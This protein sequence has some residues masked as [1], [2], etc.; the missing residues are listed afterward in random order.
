MKG[1]KTSDVVRAVYGIRARFG[2][3]LYKLFLLLTI[4]VSLAAPTARTFAIGDDTLDL[5][6]SNR[7][8]YYN[9]DGGTVN[10]DSGQR[11]GGNQI[12]LIGDSLSVGAAKQISNKMPG[13]NYEARTYDGVKY[14]LIQNSKHFALDVPDNA[15]GITIAKKLKEHNELREYLIFAL[16]TNDPGA[17]KESTIQ[18]LVDAVGAEQKIVLV[19]NASDGAAGANNYDSNNKAIRDAANANIKVADWA[20]VVGNNSYGYISDSNY[21]VHLSENGD[22]A[23]AQT[24]YDGVYQFSGSLSNMSGS[25][26]GGKV[27]VGNTMVSGGSNEEVVWNWL[28]T[29]IPSLTAEQ[30]SAIMGNIKGGSS[31]NP[32]ADN[33]TYFGIF[34]MGQGRRSGLESF[35][36]ANGIT[37]FSG[38]H[39]K[40]EIYK[41]LCLELEYAFTKDERAVGFLEN[42][43]RVQ[44]LSGAEAVKAY[45][46]IW[47]V[48]MEGAINTKDHPGQPLAYKEFV[49]WSPYYNDGHN[50]TGYYQGATTREE[51][52]VQFY[53]KF[54]NGTGSGASNLLCPS[55]GAIY[56]VDGYTFPI[57]N[58]TKSNYLNPGGKLETAL[59]KL[60]C[61]SRACHHDYAAVDMGIDA[62]SAGFTQDQSEL[63][64]GYSDMY[65]YSMGAKVVALTSGKFKNY[66]TYSN[67]V[68]GYQDKCA[69]VT[70]EADDGKVF[71]LGHMSYD[72]AMAQKYR[73]GDHIEEGEVIG[74]I[75]PPQCA[76]GTQA[77]L[78]VQLGVHSDS[79]A[80]DEIFPLMDKLWEALPNG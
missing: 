16:G 33:G 38:R 48:H 58:A 68:G 3:V 23:Y 47:V 70:F 37:S 62:V 43:H 69:S 21:H 10:C 60:P 2:G 31:F 61:P 63:G 28:T 42:L 20:E 12:T 51:Y 59:S 44:G 67:A 73:N 35:L 25:G 27:P 29:N 34:Q 32:F 8:Y 36:R 18:E 17:V 65:Y 7:A 56:D 15:S 49:T 71:W 5:L 50:G 11:I 46:D 41:A 24:L 79:R 78:H 72:P 52:S 26:E 22:K 76:I 39:T 45:S 64:K 40:E 4:C 19:T 75:G 54:G 77:H 14:Q 1:R 9:P 13:I 30:K 6:Y 55:N 53:V 66:H 80:S 74:E 57:M